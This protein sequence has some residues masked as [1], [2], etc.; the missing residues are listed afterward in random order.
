MLGDEEQGKKWEFVWL[1]LRFLSD[2]YRAR[3]SARIINSMP[4]ISGLKL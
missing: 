1:C 3:Y 2:L 4:L